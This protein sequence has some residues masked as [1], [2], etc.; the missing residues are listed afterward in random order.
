[1]LLLLLDFDGTLA[2]I[3]RDPGRATL[4]ASTRELLTRLAARRDVALAVVSGRTVA[5]LRRRVGISGIHYAGCHGL[6]IQGPGLRYRHPRAAAYKPVMKR[7]ARCLKTR[8]DGFTGVLVEDKG[9]DVAVHYRTAGR[10]GIAAARR[11]AAE[12]A[13]RHA[14]DCRLE[15][16]RL[17]Y[18]FKPRIAWDKGRAVRLL[19]SR[20]RSRQ[21]FP[22][23]IG[24][25]LTD[26]SAF[27]AVA[28]RGLAMLVDN[29]ERP[30]RT[31]APVRARSMSAA[32]RLLLALTGAG[33]AWRPGR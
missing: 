13:R 5:D 17:V 22:V 23:Y 2:P 10:R 8:L 27:R 20:F 16:G 21:P 15:R 33:C 25:D 7:I 6:E 11:A 32:R 29:P 12:V 4:A 26:E 18:E 19:L 24:D 3:R 14:R 30:S 1:M 28:G 9:Y 31:A